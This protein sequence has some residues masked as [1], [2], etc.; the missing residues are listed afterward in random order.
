M[1]GTALSASIGGNRQSLYAS[2]LLGSLALGLS[3]S[4]FEEIKRQARRT[5]ATWSR[6]DST[7]AVVLGAGAEVLLLASILVLHTP[8]TR[9]VGLVLA[10]AYAAAC[11]YFVTERRRA[12]AEAKPAKNS[13]SAATGIEEHFP[14]TSE[15]GVISPPS[16]ASAAAF[17]DSGQPDRSL[18]EH[19]AAPLHDVNA[20]GTV[21]HRSHPAGIGHAATAAHPTQGRISAAQTAAAHPAGGSTRPLSP[22]QATHSHPSTRSHP[23][24]HSHWKPSSHGPQNHPATAT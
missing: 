13:R 22:G 23:G 14:T 5:S 6:S 7:N 2:L 1:G 8:A 11:G 15:L 18:Y 21:E 17:S 24:T 4:L 16:P 9:A 3:H 10:V 12:L 20:T 19:M